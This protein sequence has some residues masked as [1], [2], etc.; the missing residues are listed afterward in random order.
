MF[1]LPFV[2]RAFLAGIPL[3]ICSSLLGVPLVLKRYSMIGDGLSH[4]AFGALSIATVL[5]IAPIEFAIPIVILSAFLLLRISDSSK[6]NADAAIGLIAT[7]ALSIGVI[8]LSASSGVNI[9]VSNYLFGN[10][11]AIDKK[12]VIL[13]IIL[14][15]VIIAIYILLYNR[16]FA[17]VFDENF[18]HATGIKV[19]LYKT[20]LSILISLTIVVGMR[21]I[22]TMLMSALIIVPALSSLQISKSFKSVIILSTLFSLFSMLSGLN[23]SYIFPIPAGACIIISNI[24]VFIIVNLIARLIVFFK[25]NKKYNMVNLK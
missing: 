19:N 15:L 7:G 4:V 16:I 1:S 22:G 17:V 18:S 13:C 9:D 5:N 8:A 23:I 11:Y 12:E 10:I 21:L 20:V 24:I 25:K 14:L 6:I 2:V 3:A